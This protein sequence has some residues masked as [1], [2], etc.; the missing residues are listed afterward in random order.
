MMENESESGCELIGKEKLRMI[1]LK[2][3][4]AAVAKYHEHPL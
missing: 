4:H 1:E 3:Y 2:L